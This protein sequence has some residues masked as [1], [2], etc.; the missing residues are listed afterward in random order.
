MST[1]GTVMTTRGITKLAMMSLQH[2]YTPTTWTV[3]LSA[4]PIAPQSQDNC[5]PERSKPGLQMFS[6]ESKERSTKMRMRCLAM[7]SI[8][9]SCFL[10]FAHSCI[11]FPACFLASLLCNWALSIPNTHALVHSQDGD[12]VLEDTESE[13][14]LESALRQLQRER[15]QMLFDQIRKKTLFMTPLTEVPKRA[16]VSI[17]VALCERTEKSIIAK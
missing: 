13:K 5:I 11:R 2:R 14:R 17:P 4:L 6:N 15:Y 12:V 16:E 1:R 10:S 3:Q 8:L 7:F 9:P